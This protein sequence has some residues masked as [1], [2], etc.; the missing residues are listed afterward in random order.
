[1]RALTWHGSHDVRVETVDPVPLGTTTLAELSVAVPAYTGPGRYDLVDLMRR[2]EAGE[3]EWWEV[4][5]LY[6]APHTEAD[7][8]IWYPDLNA[9][10]AWVEV[11]EDA[12]A[13]DLPMQS[14]L[15]AVRLTGRV[16]TGS[17]R[18]AS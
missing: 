9:G 13:F 10:E 18:A 12:V 8:A 11:T 2:G 1:M 16:A 17:T 3:I 7:D 6:L 4:L 14:A 15:S 5:D